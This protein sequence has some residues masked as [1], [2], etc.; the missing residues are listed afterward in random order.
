MTTGLSKYRRGSASGEKPGQV[1][2]VARPAY[3]SGLLAIWPPPAVLNAP[4]TGAGKEHHHESGERRRECG[5]EHRY[6]DSN[7]GF[8]TE[9]PAS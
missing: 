5:P 3:R 7:P 2:T 4:A 9:N 6:R 1:Q 8:R